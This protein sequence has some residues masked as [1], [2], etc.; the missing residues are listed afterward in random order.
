[1]GGPFFLLGRNVPLWSDRAALANRP[2]PG[3]NATTITVSLP[4]TADHIFRARL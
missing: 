3:E 2:P 1:M 4:V